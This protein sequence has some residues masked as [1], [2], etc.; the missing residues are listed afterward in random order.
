MKNGTFLRD[1]EKD[2]F[3]EQSPQ[4]IFERLATYESQATVKEQLFTIETSL[5]KNLFREQSFSTETSFSS[6]VLEARLPSNLSISNPIK[7]YRDYI[8]N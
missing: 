8:L 4:E 7:F 1:K 5:F 6:I 3:E 2:P